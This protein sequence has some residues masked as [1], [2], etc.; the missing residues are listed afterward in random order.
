LRNTVGNIP[1]KWYDEHEHIG[2]DWDGKKIEKSA[3]AMK[4]KGAIDRFLEQ[5]EDVDYW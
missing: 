4:D 2:Y 3:E 1:V 5:I